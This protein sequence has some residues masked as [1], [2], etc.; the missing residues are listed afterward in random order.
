[1]D[2]QSEDDDVWE[3]LRL[4]G[5]AVISAFVTAAVV[6]GAGSALLPA[7]LD[8]PDTPAVIRVSANR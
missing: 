2:R 8:E 5:V 6:I 7:L 1:M 4:T 3:G